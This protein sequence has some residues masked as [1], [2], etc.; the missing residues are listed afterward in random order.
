MDKRKKILLVSILIGAILAAYWYYR[1][2]STEATS[3]EPPAP[4]IGTMSAEI[5]EAVKSGMTIKERAAQYSAGKIIS[6]GT[7]KEIA[8]YYRYNPLEN[9][10]LNP[11]I[12]PGFIIRQLRKK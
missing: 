12:L 3:E 11:I 10:F 1:T 8:G 9:P 2:R 7:P 6:Q 4:Q 5:G